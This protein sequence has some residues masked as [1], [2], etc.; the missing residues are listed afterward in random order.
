MGRCEALA[1]DESTPS[2]VLSFFALIFCH[3]H[4][5][6]NESKLMVGYDYHLIFI[7]K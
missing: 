4:A 7:L 5:P 6:G 3:N 1:Q 2:P